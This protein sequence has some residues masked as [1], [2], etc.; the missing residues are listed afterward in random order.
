MC[1][2]GGVECAWVSGTTCNAFVIRK[3]VMIGNPGLGNRNHLAPFSPHPL[4]TYPLPHPRF[5]ERGAGMSTTIEAQLRSQLNRNFVLM[6]HLSEAFK[7]DD[8]TR[9]V[10]LKDELRAGSRNV[11]VLRDTLVIEI[12]RDALSD[13]KEPEHTRE[14]PD[15]QPEAK[16]RKVS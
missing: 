7:R 3:A 5:A 16:R 12:R 8:T 2:G 14:R 4:A 1:A 15:A 11:R 10:H 13:T 9:V 6:V